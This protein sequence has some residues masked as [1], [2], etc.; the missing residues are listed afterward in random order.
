MR[1]KLVIFIILLYP[2]LTK[3]QNAT[4][5]LGNYTSCAGENVLVPM[6][7]T[8]FNDVGA[9]TIYISYDTNS[10]EF[11]SLININPAIPGFVSYNGSNGLI[12]IAYSY[13]VPFYI[14]GEKLFDLSFTFLGD[15]TLLS[16]LPGT[17]IA[18]TILEV[19]PLDTFNGSI[20]NS[21]QI[22]NQPDSVQSYPNNDVIFRVTS[23]GNPEYQWQVNTGSGWNNLQN[24][25]IYTGVNNDTLFINNVPLSF[26][27]YLY[28]CELTADACVVISD[29]ALLEV[30]LAFPVAS[31][32]YISSC[33]GNELA[34]P[35]L[36]GD[37]FDVIEF[38]F[39]ISFDTTSLTYLDL[40]NIH[41]D[42]QTGNLT[43][44]PIVTPAG[45]SVHWTDLTPVSI[46]SGKLFDL[47]FSYEDMDHV[48]AF[49]AGTEVLN[50]FLN[51]IDITLNNGEIT[52][53][54]IPVII[55]QPLNDSVTEPNEAHFETEA[56]GTITYQWTLST[57]GGAS[58]TDLDNTPPYFNVNSSLLTINPAVFSMNGYQFACR[59]GS[60]QCSVTSVAASL[61]VDTLTFIGMPGEIQSINVY[62]VPFHDMLK[63]SISGKSDYNTINIYDTR[64]TIVYSSGLNNPDHSDNLTLNLT[65][66][67]EG[68]FFLEMTGMHDGKLSK[69]NKK[70]LKIN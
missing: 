16:F 32:G 21:I 19:I 11:I 67:H 51:P 5:T 7:V 49:E 60:E 42:L 37:F 3:S 58:W 69:I 31:L 25:S 35:L 34:E 6:D 52:Q 30:A 27:G 57:D 23:L 36:A 38:T 1:I 54:E 24:S 40:V 68:L 17:E 18:N 43:V 26:N 46:T 41:P 53:Y 61:F 8:D 9:M 13:T 39:N 20:F 33:P 55:S 48:F 22:V 44:E 15:S 47:M 2:M 70:I 56:S 45:I 10:A 29:T 4:A 65:G 62:P 12:S 28:R 14:T 63:I 66:L 64:G 59:L 50:S